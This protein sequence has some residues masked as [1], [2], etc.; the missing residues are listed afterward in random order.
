MQE[1]KCFL[2]MLQI[3]P[4]EPKACL[5]LVIP[6]ENLLKE[7]KPYLGQSKQSQFLF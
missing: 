1:V 5:I 7:A 2:W 3:R 6:I 4:K